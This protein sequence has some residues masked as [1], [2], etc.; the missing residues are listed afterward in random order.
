MNGYLHRAKTKVD[1]FDDLTKKKEILETLKR[2]VRLYE[3]LCAA[4]RFEDVELHKKYIFISYL[5][6]YIKIDGAGPG[7]SLD[8]KL[9]ASG[10]IQKKAKEIKKSNITPNP[11]LK[12]PNTH[13]ISITESNEKKLSEI[14][15]EINAR[16]GKDFSTDVAKRVAIQIRDLMRKNEE[17]RN[18]ARNNSE[19]DFEFSYFDHIDEALIDA[20][21]EDKEFSSF[22]LK[23]ED[24]KK[25]L[26]GIFAQE[27]YKTLRN[28]EST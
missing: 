21:A 24:I 15:D 20:M 18:S 25:Q 7:F 10:F 23:N 14:I 3:F 27:I 26:M 12:L 19:K 11:V 8:G 1:E 13:E 6:S 16:T 5:V 2:F 28:T 17:L 9:R 4:T 22:L